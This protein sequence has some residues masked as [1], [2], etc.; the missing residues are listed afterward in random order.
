MEFWKDGADRLHD[1]MLF[2][3]SEGGWTRMRLY[4]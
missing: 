1:R 4:P 3:R 2:I